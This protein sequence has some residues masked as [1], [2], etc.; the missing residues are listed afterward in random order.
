MTNDLE[1]LIT[2]LLSI[3]SALW[4]EHNRRLD[5]QK[6]IKSFR[7][8]LGPHNIVLVVAVGVKFLSF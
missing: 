2:I 7:S 8:V 1:Q 6:K 3:V 5:T 4:M